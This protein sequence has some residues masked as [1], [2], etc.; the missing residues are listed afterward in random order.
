MFSL[1]RTILLAVC[2]VA[3]ATNVVVA[4]D[5]RTELEEID[6]LKRELETER[7]KNQIAKVKEETRRLEVP[8]EPPEVKL[9]ATPASKGEA[10]RPYRGKESTES[11]AP[12]VLVLAIQGIDGRNTAT[13]SYDGQSV[14]EVGKGAALPDGSRVQNISNSSVVL[15]QGGKEHHYPVINLDNSQEW[16]GGHAR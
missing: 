13:I 3:C 8:L 5:T 7:L 6:R 15:L 2:M 14:M 4:Q 10:S 12:S 9:P 1:V 11:M 16:R